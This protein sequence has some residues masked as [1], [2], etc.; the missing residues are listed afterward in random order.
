MFSFTL[1]FM[2][3]T[4]LGALVM[5]LLSLAGQGPRPPGE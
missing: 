5:V 1:G 2:T 3:G 4:F